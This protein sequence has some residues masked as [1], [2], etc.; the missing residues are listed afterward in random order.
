MCGAGLKDRRTG[1]NQSFDPYGKPVLPFRHG[2]TGRQW[3]I[4]MPN[5]S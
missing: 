1:K 4:H 3:F 2:G 5:Q